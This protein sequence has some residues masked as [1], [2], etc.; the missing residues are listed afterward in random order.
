MANIIYYNLG[1]FRMKCQE[2]FKC[3]FVVN[4]NKNFNLE[5]E[6]YLNVNRHKQNYTST[7]GLFKNWTLNV[8]K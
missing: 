8:E 1:N 5:Q 4:G 7:R 2:I 6:S 3:S